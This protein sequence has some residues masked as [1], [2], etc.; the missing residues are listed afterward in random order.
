MEG[1]P[2]A[3]APDSET[4]S[5]EAVHSTLLAY[6]ATF[7][8]RV[9]SM[10]TEARKVTAQLQTLRRNMLLFAGKQKVTKSPASSP[11]SECQ[12]RTRL[13]KSPVPLF[14]PASTMPKPFV[15]DMPGEKNFAILRLDC[16]SDS[17]YT[18]RRFPA[19]YIK[20]I[21]PRT[22]EIVKGVADMTYTIR[23]LDGR[24][25][26]VD[27]KIQ[28]HEDVQ[29]RFNRKRLTIVNGVGE[30]NGIRFTEVSS[31]NWGFFA[32]EIEVTNTHS[33]LKETIVRSSPIV[34]KSCRCYHSLKGNLD[35][36][37]PSHSTD[38]LPDLG[39]PLAKKLRDV[40]INTIAD[41]ACKSEQEIAALQ[42]N[43]TEGFVEKD[44]C[45]AVT[46]LTEAFQQ[47]RDIASRKPATK[48]TITGT[49][50]GHQSKETH[51]DSKEAL[52]D[53]TDS[54]AGSR[55]KS[56][57]LKYIANDGIDDEA[58][59]QSALDVLVNGI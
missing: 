52:S 20:V 38:H 19:F 8:A 16:V 28:S 42:K 21:D 53:S 26:H 12:D 2:P 49:P 18:E 1:S 43:I 50:K 11:F 51:D 23:L 34:V 5:V 30:V 31:K 45:R 22:N 24:G 33:I 13:V 15:F 14:L 55:K 27:N 54:S 36:L 29:D 56:N 39:G 17:F 3:Q 9:E 6:E 58:H 57:Y 25:N 47:A 46:I 44:R 37:L 40:G 59:W 48:R 35:R 4:P 7:S 10:E 41:M 32:L